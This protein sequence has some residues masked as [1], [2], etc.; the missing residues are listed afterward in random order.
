MIG[1]SNKLLEKT[2]SPI[3]KF[4]S[5]PEVTGVSNL[6]YRKEALGVLGFPSPPEVTGVSNSLEL[7]QIKQMENC[8][9]PLPR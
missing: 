7:G 5:P 2:N 9:R 3:E 8:F 4:P 6:L 1:V